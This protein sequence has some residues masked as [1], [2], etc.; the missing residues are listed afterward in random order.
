[1]AYSA[2]RLLAQ[3]IS[4]MGVTFYSSDEHNAD[5]GDDAEINISD[6]IIPEAFFTSILAHA[7]HSMARQCLDTSALSVAGANY[8]ELLTQALKLNPLGA[9]F[10]FDHLAMF[11]VRATVPD[12]GDDPLSTLRILTIASSA[13]RQ[14]GLSQN[15]RIDLTERFIAIADDTQLFEGLLIEEAQEE[16][17]QNVEPINFRDNA[18]HPD[19]S[20]LVSDGNIR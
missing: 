9:K 1:M 5:G 20:L 7:A 2:H 12:I 3:F 11:G 14:L 17:H 18:P 16:Q 8:Q 4:E 19:A 15:A 6:A 13:K 10:Y